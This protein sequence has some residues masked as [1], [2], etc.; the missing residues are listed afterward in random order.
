MENSIAV[1]NYFIKKA[2]EQG[3]EVT[4]MKLL[5][6]V[7]ISHGYHL[8]MFGEGL[9]A[10]PVEAWQYGPVVKSVYYEFR[11]FGKGRVNSYGSIEV[12]GNTITPMPNAEKTEFLDKVWAAYGKFDG[13]QL[14]TLT[15][16]KDTPWDITWRQMGGKNILSAIINPDIIKE[17]YKSLLKQ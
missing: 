11:K 7:Y 8:A 13:L 3:A 12:N 15:H 14:S 5:K 17:H 9:I 4:P 16:Q 10:E 1:A 2:S 6:L